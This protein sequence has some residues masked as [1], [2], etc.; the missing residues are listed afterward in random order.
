MAVADYDRSLELEQSGAPARDR[1]TH[2]WEGEP[3]L[4]GW[5][6]TVDHK[7]YGKRYIATAFLF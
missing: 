6:S 7:E 2:I 5:L 4:K 1:L 3:G